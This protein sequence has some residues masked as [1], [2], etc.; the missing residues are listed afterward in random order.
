[1]QVEK[2]WRMH[3]TNCSTYNA[4]FDGDE[5]NVHFPQ[6]FQGQSE[7]ANIAFTDHQY[8]VPKSGA[9]LRGL[10]Q[11]SVVTG[12]YCRVKVSNSV[13]RGIINKTRYISD[14]RRVSTPCLWG[15]SEYWSPCHRNPAPSCMETCSPMDWEAS[16]MQG[17][18]ERTY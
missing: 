16:G 6:T 1:M 7:A 10:I 13:P 3:Y 11:D 15:V 12:K 8:V 18:S 9:P 4:D 5:M 2:T 14:S 17:Y